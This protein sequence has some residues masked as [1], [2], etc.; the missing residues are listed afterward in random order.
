MAPLEGEARQ[1]DPYHKDN[2]LIAS[3]AMNA[4]NKA[5]FM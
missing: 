3:A 4:V 1:E 5:T 2:A